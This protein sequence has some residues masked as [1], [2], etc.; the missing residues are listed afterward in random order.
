MKTQARVR[1]AS[2]VA[3]AALLAGPALAAG[4]AKSPGAAAQAAH[5]ARVKAFA[6]LPDWTGIYL[7]TGSLFDQSRGATN[8]NSD[9]NAR[10]YPPYKPEWEARYQNFLDTV[11]KT[12]KYIDP[13]TLC[14]PAGFP[15]L[16]SAIFGIEFVVRPE[17]TLIIFERN[18]VRHIFTDG[19]PHPS[20]GD[21]WPSWE[22]HSIGHWEGDTLVVETVAM[23]AGVPVD[24]TGLV[25]SEQARVVERIRK[26][27]PNTLED[28]LTLYDPVAFTGP[29]KVRRV[30]HKQTAE[31]YPTIGTVA[32]AES[33]RNPV[34]NSENTVVLGSERP[35]VTE[36]YPPEIIKFAVPYNASG[37]RPLAVAGP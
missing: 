1:F 17:E 30:Y 12:G 3:G 10:D 25:L 24:R 36:M 7:G 28:Q 2:I 13:L 11:V 32:C 16:A 23:K 22:G 19:R 9:Y 14:Y 29:W 20:G 34:V 27:D 4:A 21:L 26:V 6:A 15:R 35:G 37:T 18:G 5:D 31:K 8:P 33:Q